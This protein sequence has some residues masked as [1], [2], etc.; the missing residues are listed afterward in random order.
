MKSTH[1]PPTV[2]ISII[3]IQCVGFVAAALLQS[4]E[5]VRRNDGQAI[6]YFKSA[7]WRQEFTA[8]P[9]SILTPAVLLVSLA[10]FSSQLNLV[11]TGSVNAFYFNIRTRALANVSKYELD[12]KYSF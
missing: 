2:Y 10:L 7:T 1:V 3:I 8:L 6:A 9:K 12:L 4:P 5:K 11:L